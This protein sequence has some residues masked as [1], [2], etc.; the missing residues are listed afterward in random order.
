MRQ[1]ILISVVL[2][3][4]LLAGPAMAEQ[5]VQF[6][7]GTSMPIRSHKIQGEMIH[8]DLGNDGFIAFPVSMIDRVVDAGKDVVISPSSTGNNKV[9]GRVET[10]P[11]GSFPVRGQRPAE[12]GSARARNEAA[13]AANDPQFDRDERG[14]A[15]HRPYAGGGH[16]AKARMGAV[17]NRASFQRRDGSVQ[18]GGKTVIGPTG[19]PRGNRPQVYG[20]AIKS[21]GPSGNRPSQATA[22]PA[23]SGNAAGGNSQGSGSGD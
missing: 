7:N 4:F 12:S 21:G 16:A 20:M 5:I 11:T 22:A 23:P 9:M 6:A 10:D 18:R 8:V 2:G 15:V 3:I 1:K 14:M 13:L 17:G 19:G